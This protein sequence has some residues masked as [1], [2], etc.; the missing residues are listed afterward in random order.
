LAIARLICIESA[1]LLIMLCY[2]LFGTMHH[3]LLEDKQR[4]WSGGFD[5]SKIYIIF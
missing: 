2:I 3:S 1:M 5:H 4:F